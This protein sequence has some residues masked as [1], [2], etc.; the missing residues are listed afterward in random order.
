[1]PTRNMSVSSGCFSLCLI[2]SSMSNCSYVLTLFY[3]HVKLTAF[4]ATQLCIC[5]SYSLNSLPS[6]PGE[7]LIAHDDPMKHHLLSET[8]PDLPE[9]VT[10]FQALP[11]CLNMA[12]CKTYRTQEKKHRWEPTYHMSKCLRSYKSS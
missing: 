1:M 8:M 12:D 10:L 9:L 11:W 3:A 5:R 4:P 7:L 2:A 6:L